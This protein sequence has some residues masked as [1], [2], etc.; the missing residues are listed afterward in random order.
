MGERRR[1]TNKRKKGTVRHFPKT[2]YL[3]RKI[4]WFDENK[5][6]RT[7]KNEKKELQTKIELRKREIRN[8]Y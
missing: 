3:P 1:F 2:D 6:T 5:K 7:I 8:P 4:S